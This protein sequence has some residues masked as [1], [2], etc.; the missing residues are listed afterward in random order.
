MKISSYWLKIIVLLVLCALFST[1][2]LTYNTYGNFAFAFALRGKKILAFILVAL[3]TSVSTISFQ[4]L[5]RNQ[6]LTP[7]I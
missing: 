1:L 3:A 4:T 6:F 2:Y 5:T 7:G